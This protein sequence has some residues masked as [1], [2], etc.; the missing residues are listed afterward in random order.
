MNLKKVIYPVLFLL[1]S[2]PSKSQVSRVFLS[3]LMYNVIA[4][5]SFVDINTLEPLQYQN[6]YIDLP[7]QNVSSA[8]ALKHQKCLVINALDYGDG[9]TP[10]SFNKS[11]FYEPSKNVNRYDALVAVMEAWDVGVDFTGSV[12]YNDI[13]DDNPYFPYINKA[14]AE[15]LL[16]N[17]FSGSNFNGNQNITTGELAQLIA[18]IHFYYPKDIRDLQ[19]SNNYLIPSLSALQILSTSR[20]L[21]QGI[22]NH[23]AKN[24]FTIP[25]RLLNLE[26]SHFYSTMMVERPAGVYPIRPLG[27]GWSH[28]YNSY[29]YMDVIE[30]PEVIPSPFE[31]Y[32][33]V[34]PDGTLHLY[35]KAQANSSVQDYWSH[36][37][38]DELDFQ[39]GENRIVITKKN[40]VEYTYNKLDNDR[41]IWYLTKIEEPNG[42]DIEIDY[43]S[44]EEDDTRRIE[45]V[46]S[47]SGKSLLFTYYNNTDLIRVIT[48]PIGREIEFDYQNKEP[49]F[50]HEYPILDEFTDAKNQRTDYSYTTSRGLGKHIM[51][52]IELPRGNKITADYDN[53]YKLTEYQINN[54]KPIKIDVDINYT[55]TEVIRTEI[56]IPTNGSSVHRN[57]YA[58]DSKDRMVRFENEHQAVQSVYNNTGKLLMLPNSSEINGVEADYEFDNDGNITQLTYSTGNADITHEFDYDSDNN[59]TEYT[60]PD[61]NITEFVY[62]GNENLVEIIDAYNNSTFFSYDTYGQL[63]SSTNQEGIT[64]TRT[65]EFDGALSSITAPAGI[66][67][68]FSYD[69]VN[70]LLQQNLNGLITQFQYDANDNI[71]KITNAL[72]FVTNYSFDPN[73]NLSTLTNAKG[74]IS[75]FTYNNEDQ[76]L[77]YQFD[78]LVTSYDYNDDGTLEEVSK[79]SGQKFAVEYNRDGLPDEIGTVSDITYTNQ[80]LPREVTNPSGT[81]VF[82]Y[83]N[84]YRVDEVST[85]HG[86]DVGYDYTKTG[87]VDEIVYP[88]INGNNLEVTYGYDDKNRVF[89][90]A[91]NWKNNYTTVADY[92]FL[93]DDR[94]QFV[95]YG[96][97]TRTFY[98]YDNAARLKEISHRKSDLSNV[99]TGIYTYDVHNNITREQNIFLDMGE[100]S[101]VPKIETTNTQNYTYNNTNHIVTG[102]GEAFSVNTDGNVINLGSGNTATFTLEDRLSTF[103][104]SGVGTTFKYNAYGQR[105]EA[106]RGGIVTKYVRDVLSDNV[107]IE[108]DGSNNPLFYYI[109]HPNGTLIARLR[110]NGDLHYYHGDIRGSTIAISDA[111]ESITHQYRYKPFGEIS[112]YI[113]PISEPNPFKYVGTYGVEFE[114]NDLYYMRARYY[115]PSTGRFISQDPIWHDNLYPYADNNPIA[116]IDP[117]GQFGNPVNIAIDIAIDK[118]V[119]M[120]E[121]NLEYLQ[122]KLNREYI[123]TGKFSL[124]TQILIAGNSLW[125]NDW[126]RN[127]LLFAL[128]RGS[129]F[130][131]FYGKG[132]TKLFGKTGLLGAVD[133]RTL[134]GRLLKDFSHYV[135]KQIEG[136]V[137]EEVV[138]FINQKVATI[139]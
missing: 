71:T 23:Y 61:G 85:V 121:S 60:D 113:E 82:G 36:S 9:N 22:F 103:T 5:S 129:G 94:I 108:L 122:N 15:N 125:A 52:E 99:F 104:S 12:S 134:D 65:Y 133:M 137:K 72:G 138:D 13:D 111:A 35:Y 24:S 73:D 130:K 19:N 44:A 131:S 21:T 2:L 87:L 66:S 63:T 83:D 59:L 11:L 39:N 110:I 45:E 106:N 25:D 135:G 34:W 1:L 77:T 123:E 43:E 70:R 40:Q 14:A 6:Q 33:I 38:F 100:S 64:I 91:I 105:V 92:T 69:D 88:T 10:F 54:N 58:Y 126:S 57:E 78:N 112:E 139:K 50:I 8:I 120:A 97:N 93:K 118:S 127:A 101:T 76:P 114:R 116:K 115:Q 119:E 17:V 41:D 37:V 47:P 3:E 62:D 27:R 136:E 30:N 98:F 26:F 46:F 75:S 67:V 49:D 18:N 86:Y 81:I 84:F 56:E 109:W 96:N 68:Q 51:D 20:G 128:R 7:V 117:N 42:N 79:P 107:L 74:V 32:N 132:S 48:D 4:G 16:N 31:F 80:G 28:P 102:N 53:E 95:L 124:G 89:D 29:I 90:I 55:R